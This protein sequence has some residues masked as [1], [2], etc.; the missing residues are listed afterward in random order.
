MMVG[1][2]GGEEG[3]SVVSSFGLHDGLRQSGSAQRARAERPEPKGSG[4][5][6]RRGGSDTAESRALTMRGEGGGCT[7]GYDDLLCLEL[8]GR[9]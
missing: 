9:I 8:L 3:N 2:R 6:E 1:F 7:C 4:Y 5:L